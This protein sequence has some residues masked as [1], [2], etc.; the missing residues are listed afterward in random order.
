MRKLLCLLIA[1]LILAAPVVAA[2]VDPYTAIS[3]MGKSWYQGYEPTV[4]N[5]TMTIYL[6]IK[7]EL[8]GPVSVSIALTDPNVYLLA[9]QPKAVTVTEKDGI[10]HVKLTLNLQK[11]RR[12]G[13]YPAVIT[14]KSGSKTE[15]LPYTIRIRDGRGSH[16]TL[17]PILSDV[18]GDLDVGT[19]GSLNLTITNPTSTLSMI[20]GVLTITDPTGEVLMSGS[21]RF[22][23]PEVL[24][25]GSVTVSVPM[26]VL[27]NAAIRVH[28]LNVTLSCAVLGTETKWEEA[29]TV[30]VTQAIRLEHGDAQLPP[31]IAGEL[32]NLTLPLMNLG[33]GELSNILVK[34]ET[35]AANGQSVLVGTLAP[36]ETKQAQLTFTPFADSIGTHSGT[37]TV[38]CEDAYGN[39]FAETMEVTLTVDEPLPEVSEEPQQ[40][41]KTDPKSILLTVLCVLLTAG[42]IAQHQILTARLHKLEE[43]RL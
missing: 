10:Y 40:K 20:G 18:T 8:E 17:S 42:L 41:E 24:P 25:G 31:A 26:T 2:E 16:E 22:P 23:V 30:P 27:G 19:E 36:G 35:S 29:F 43:E 7:S 39:T 12:N 21:D 13:D 9:S 32:G 4:K 15:T 11:D 5:N 6:P 33:K 38:T 1:I 3:G 28:T 14:L 34:L 37:V